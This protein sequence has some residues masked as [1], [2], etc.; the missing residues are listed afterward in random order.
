MIIKI[1]EGITTFVAFVVILVIV[2]IAFAGN[3][4]ILFEGRDFEGFTSMDHTL[5]DVH[6]FIYVKTLNIDDMRHL[7]SCATFLKSVYGFCSNCFAEFV[8]CHHG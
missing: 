1:L 5:Y 3:F 6:R 8:N 2:I 4:Y 7:I